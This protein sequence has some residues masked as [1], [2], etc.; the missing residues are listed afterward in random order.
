MKIGVT[1]LG[2]MAPQ[3]CRSHIMGGLWALMRAWQNTFFGS[4]ESIEETNTQ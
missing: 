1:G 3:D 4:I 2:G